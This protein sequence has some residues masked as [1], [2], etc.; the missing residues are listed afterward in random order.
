MREFA[1]GLLPLYRTAYT[2]VSKGTVMLRR[3][4]VTP[5]L[6]C[7]GVA[8]AAEV[9]DSACRAIQTSDRNPH[10][11]SDGP[12]ATILPW[13]TAPDPIVRLPGSGP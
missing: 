10:V 5:P 7:S 4:I 13:A 2:E 6:L 3:L 11:V 8:L 9:T 1:P 12:P